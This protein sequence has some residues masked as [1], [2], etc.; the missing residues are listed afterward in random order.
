[1]PPREPKRRDPDTNEP[2]CEDHL[3]RRELAAFLAGMRAAWI[4]ALHDEKRRPEGDWAWVWSVGWMRPAARPA[5][6][7]KGAR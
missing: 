7:S 1:M 5:G 4:E 2:L 6:K 3:S